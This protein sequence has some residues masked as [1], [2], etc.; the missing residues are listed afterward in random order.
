MNEMF[1]IKS[2]TAQKVW[3]NFDRELIHKLK[4]LPVEEQKD[5][6]LEILSHLYEATMSNDSEESSN[7]QSEEVRLINAISNLGSPE[8]YLDPLISDILVYQKASKGHPGAILQGLKNSAKQGLF[9]ALAT[10]VLGM[11]YFW[12][13]VIFVMSVMHIANPDIGIWYYPTGEIS[14]SFEAQPGA[15]QWMTGKFSLI[16]ITASLLAYWLLS[17]ILSYFIVRLK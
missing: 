15:Q 4:L 16:G 11:G 3:D 17:K 13:I 12:T 8:V 10:F 1:P 5:I 2:Q 14:L 6:R 7:E 9:H